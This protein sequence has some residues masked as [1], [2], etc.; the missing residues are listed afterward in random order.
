[1]MTQLFQPL[2][3][4][5][6]V[7]FRIAFGILAFADVL[8]TWLYYHVQERAYQPEN[9][10]FSYIG[11]EWVQPLPEPWMSAFFIILLLNAIGI[12]IGWRYVLN[13]L[14]FAVGFTW[15]FL[16]EKAH[17][18]NHGYL[19]CWISFLMIVLPAHRCWSFD[20]HRN[21][22][23]RSAVTPAWCIWI[24][25]FLMAVV[26]FYGGLAKLNGDWLR[27]VPLKAWLQQK[28]SFPLI[29]PALAWPGTAYFMAYGGLLFD[30]MAPFGLFFRKTRL[31]VF[32]LAIG[33]HLLNTLVF[34]IGIFPALSICLTALFFS[35]DFP[36]V[37]ARKLL[38]RVQESSFSWIAENRNMEYW[39]FEPGYR[40]SISG[41]LV[42]VVSVHL[43]IPL[44]QHLFKGNV[45]WTEE[46]HRYSWRMMLRSKQG[47]GHFTVK[48]LDT[49][50]EETIR[51]SRYLSKRQN[52]KLYAH[53]DMIWQFARY[54]RQ[55]YQQKGK[56]VAVYAHIQTRLNDNPYQSFIDPDVDL[57]SVEWTHF[58]SALW[59]MP[60]EH[61]P[62]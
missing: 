2:S 16:L 32:I 52:R 33:F 22:D 20:A 19:F 59:I 48:N 42:L 31:F 37:W 10:R 39:Q 58:K 6:L 30:L 36:F 12:I 60:P 44:R 28:S 61:R 9:F 50:E 38:A 27:A 56:R 25:P 18:L 46:G 14:F 26:Y 47:Y 54:L 3:I 8:G 24:L 55:L 29:G 23:L 1:M 62:G 41:F 51:P 34:Q 21:P 40:K 7:F 45:A 43:L 4:A 35:P 13:A 49:G 17:Y 57:G 53:P 5:S 11:F 15:L